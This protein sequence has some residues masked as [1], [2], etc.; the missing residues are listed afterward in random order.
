VI[1]FL[2]TE[3]T[4]FGL[5]DL[6]LAVEVVRE[7]RIPHGVVINCDGIGDDRVVKYCE[8][9]DIPLLLSIPWSREIAE[10]YSRG[11]PI[12]DVFPDLKG[13]LK[14]LFQEIN[15]LIQE[16]RAEVCSGM[17]IDRNIGEI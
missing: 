10:A 9:E 4:P 11:I 3:P 7:L 1:S 16:R 2:V 8:E 5:N 6:K 13:Q 15:G 14:S 17:T 12:T